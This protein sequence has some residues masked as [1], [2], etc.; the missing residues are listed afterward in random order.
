MYVYKSPTLFLQRLLLWKSCYGPKVTLGLS[1]WWGQSHGPSQGSRCL[2]KRLVFVDV[3]VKIKGVYFSVWERENKK[4]RREGESVI[5]YAVLETGILNSIRIYFI[6]KQT[7]WNIRYSVTG[8]S[9]TAVE[10]SRCNK[11][12]SVLYLAVSLNTLKLTLMLDSQAQCL[13][14]NSSFQ[15]VLLI[16]FP[17]KTTN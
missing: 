13:K 5:W 2:L 16:I 6:L 1:Y 8:P 11:W 12:D 17:I 3:E 4:E 15:C 14:I 10:P 7:V 9:G